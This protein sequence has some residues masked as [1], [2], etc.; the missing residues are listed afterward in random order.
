MGS[1]M[2]ARLTHRLPWLGMVVVRLG[3]QGRDEHLAFGAQVQALA[4]A[5]E[6]FGH[7]S[8]EH[9]PLHPAEKACSFL[10]KKSI[11][12]MRQNCD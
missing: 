7:H 10:L 2:L 11:L 5:M 6:C 9:H 8:H 4:R 3:C 1:Q 12:E